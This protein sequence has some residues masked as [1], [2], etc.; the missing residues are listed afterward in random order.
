MHLI[1]SRALQVGNTYCNILLAE[2]ISAIHGVV[3]VCVLNGTPNK[4]S[5]YMFQALALVVLDKYEWTR[6]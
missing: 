3:V 6:E 4:E 2:Q 5:R 1:L